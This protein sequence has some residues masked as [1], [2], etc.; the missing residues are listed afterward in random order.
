M[1]EGLEKY[2]TAVLGH[3]LGSESVVK[4]H[5]WVAISFAIKILVLGTIPANCFIIFESTVT[6]DPGRVILLLR[7]IVGA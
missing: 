5:L 4:V 7:A 3:L 6:W 1:V 2:F